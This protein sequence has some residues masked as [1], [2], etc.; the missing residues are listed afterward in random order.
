MISLPHVPLPRVLARVDSIWH[1]GGAAHHLLYGQTG[2]GKTTLIK[3]LLGL[4]AYERVLILD[5][6]QHPDPVWDDRDSPDRWGKPVTRV[7]PM[8]GDRQ[9]G[10]GPHGLWYRLTGAPDRDDT[11]RRFADALATVQAEGHCVIVL[12]DVREITR[13]LRLSLHVD[14][15]LN[16][17]RSANVLAVLSATEA[18]YVAGRAQAAQVWVGATTGLD[19]AK[20]GAGLLSWRGRDAEDAVATVAQHQW[21]YSEAQPGNAGRCLV[22]S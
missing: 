1:P 16:L 18:A 14:S 17:G 4:C 6:K 15:V 9:D 3:A 21:I 10:G 2:S 5:P 7:G 19:A 12:D 8:F 22:A 11:A 20:A 13:Q